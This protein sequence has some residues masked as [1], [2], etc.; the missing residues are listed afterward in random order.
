MYRDRILDFTNTST[1]PEC[2][3]IQCRDNVCRLFKFSVST[4]KTINVYIRRFILHL[5]VFNGHFVCETETYAMIE[6]YTK[7]YPPPP[8][9]K[10]KQPQTNP[11]KIEYLHILI[12]CL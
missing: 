1:Y 7:L 9:Q 3:D 4:M 11:L 6:K 12:V 5:S 10:K 2:Q 8:P